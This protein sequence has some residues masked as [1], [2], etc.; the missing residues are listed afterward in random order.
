MDESAY[1]A[2]SYYADL[3]LE[4]RRDDPAWLD[5]AGYD[6]PPLAKYLVGIALRAGGPS[7]PGPVGGARPGMPTRA[8]GS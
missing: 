2:Q 1:V 7:P 3:L 5:Y 8:A 6:L 4:G